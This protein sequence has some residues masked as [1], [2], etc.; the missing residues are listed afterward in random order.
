MAALRFLYK[1]SLKRNWTFEDVI[2]AA[3]KP[4][5]LPVVLSPEEVRRFLG[6]VGSTKR[7]AAVWRKALGDRQK[8]NKALVV[9][10]AHADGP[11]I[12][13]I[14]MQMIADASA[15]SLHAFVTDCVELGAA[16]YTDRWSGYAG[17]RRMAL[18]ARSPHTT[19]GRR[20]EAPNSCRASI[21]LPRC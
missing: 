11:A 9:I 15:D 14:R 17:W 10:A 16:L 6:C 3:K 2:P 5:R 19:R 12:G 20:K 18:S 21:G 7:S 8:T 4:R 1:V 13:R